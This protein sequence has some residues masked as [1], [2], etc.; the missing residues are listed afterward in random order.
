MQTVKEAWML[1]GG[2]RGDIK[3]G[4][5]MGG[6]DFLAERQEMQE[7]PAIH[8]LVISYYPIISSFFFSHLLSLSFSLSLSWI[9]WGAL[10]LTVSPLGAKRCARSGGCWTT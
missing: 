7:A 4:C 1:A 6:R 3:V 9:G 8:I 2:P 10:G 5:V